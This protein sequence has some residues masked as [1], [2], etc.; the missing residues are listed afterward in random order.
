MTP[1]PDTRIADDD[2]TA[3]QTLHRALYVIADTSKRV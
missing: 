2:L 3:M 1:A